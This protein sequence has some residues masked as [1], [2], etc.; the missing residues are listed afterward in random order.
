MFPRG[1]DFSCPS[2]RGSRFCDVRGGPA[3]TVS[4]TVASH[5]NVRPSFQGIRVCYYYYLLFLLFVLLLLLLL[6]LLLNYFV[7]PI[8]CLV[9]LE[10]IIADIVE[11][12]RGMQMMKQEYD[13]R[14]DKPTVLKTFLSSSEEKMKKLKSE[15]KAAQVIVTEHLHMVWYSSIYIA[16]LNG[17]EPTEALLVRLAPREKISFKK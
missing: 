1:G 15:S 2:S 6:L 7:A 3:A 4:T 13:G 9:S 10:N 11:L 17:R 8:F 12:E 5:S 16:P 14:A